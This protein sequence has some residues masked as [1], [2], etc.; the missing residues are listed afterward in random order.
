MKLKHIFLSTIVSACATAN[1]LAAS[2]SVILSNYDANNENGF[3]IFEDHGIGGIVAAR[4]GTFVQVW[5]GASPDA[6]FPIYAFAGTNTFVIAPSFVNGNGPGTGSFFDEGYGFVPTVAPL[7]LAYLQ[8]FTWSG[9]SSFLQ[10]HFTAGAWW[11]ET[12]IWTQNLGDNTAAPNIPN[13]AIL[14]VPAPIVE[15]APEPSTWALAGL[16]GMALLVVR[17]RGLVQ[18]QRN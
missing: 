1:L 7:G 6:M 16:G 12:Q 15:V 4:A 10:A 14:N 3:G 18:G 17:R 11:G 8:V 13:P 2:G 9:A 5:G